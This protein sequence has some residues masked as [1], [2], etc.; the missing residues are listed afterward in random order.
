VS[1]LG[2]G[3]VTLWDAGT[4]AVGNPGDGKHALASSQVSAN[5]RYCSWERYCSRH[6]SGRMSILEFAF[7]ISLDLL[8]THLRYG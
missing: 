5:M 1:A 6:A 4:R 8:S 3:T 2:D 7:K